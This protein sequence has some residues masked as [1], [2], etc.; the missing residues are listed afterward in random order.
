MGL[1]L[2][3]LL[4]L[5]LLGMAPE[6]GPITHPYGAMPSSLLTVIVV[7]LVILLLTGRL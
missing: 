4:V 7:I 6:V 1:I 3:I 5:L 2:I